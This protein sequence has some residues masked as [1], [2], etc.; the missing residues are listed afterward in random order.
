[1]QEAREENHADYRAKDGGTEETE[2][3]TQEGELGLITSVN[4]E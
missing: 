1:M 2:A 3:A 4:P